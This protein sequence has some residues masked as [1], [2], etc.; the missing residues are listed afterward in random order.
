MYISGV[1]VKL[2]LKAVIP[3]RRFYLLFENDVSLI[4]IL[5]K[6]LEFLEK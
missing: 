5:K 4:D 6:L 3:F 2:E 1:Y